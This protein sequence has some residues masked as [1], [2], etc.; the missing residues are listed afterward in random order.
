[1]AARY[2]ANYFR[3]A[4][5]RPVGTD[6]Q[7]DA[8]APMDGSGYF[9]PFTFTAGVARG[10]ENR[11]EAVVNGKK[12]RYRLGTEFEP[13]GAS[14]SGKASGEV[15][16]VGY[17]IVSK[18]PPRDD[19]AGQNVSGKIVLLLAGAPS[20]DPHSPLMEH[21]AIRRKA[22]IARDKGA[23][24][25]LVVLQKDSDN[26]Q[27]NFDS[28]PTDSGIPILV[29]RRSVGK[30]WLKA[31]DKSLDDLEK[32]LVKEPAA[33]PMGVQVDLV[34]E[35]KKVTKTSANIIG[36][37]EG[38][39]PTLKQ[40][41]VIIG[42]HM[43]HLGMGGPSSLA[44]T[45]KPVIH[46]GADD[47]AS[48]TAGVLALAQYYGSL[49]TRPKR[50]LLFICFSGEELGL[51]G[52]T[53]YV[54]NPILP[55]DRTVAMINMD[56]IGRMRN[57]RL[58]VV[59]TGTSPMWSGLVDDINKTAG[60]DIS[61][62]ESGFGASDQQSF[63]ARNIPV[64][65]FFTGLHSDYHRPSDTVEKINVEDQARVMEF[66][67]GC[68]DRIANNPERPAFQRL[69]TTQENAPVRFRVSLGTIPDYAAEVEGVMLSGVRPGSPAE[70]AGLRAGDII[71]K[72][73][74]RSI[75]NVQE[76]TIAL[77][78]HK[79][80]DVVKIVVKRGKETLTLSATLEGNRR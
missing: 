32:M 9:Q 58:I 49:S 7:N 63:Y 12:M 35:V 17:G 53:H 73:G 79:P 39:D 51:L 72:F 11:L 69:A 45:K 68:I 15:I 20:N 24:A 38:S 71:V 31:A 2:I 75:R 42:A 80:G 6:K 1:I 59:G 4:G 8:S 19:Y 33:F 3:R 34:A 37:L 18:D 74:E 61:R 10:K 76:Y 50:S 66:I 27:I 64:L 25:I 77:S 16:F 36:L 65:F 70:K 13:S 62:S 52:S 21:A 43:D 67:Q 56:M 30:S 54:K 5:L 14:A 57:N 55:L 29:L 23:K 47:N 28:T 40:E 41:V 22:L 60:F 78:E 48:G 44:E 26:P 46:H